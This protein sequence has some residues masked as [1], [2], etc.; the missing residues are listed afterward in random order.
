VT[1]IREP[2]GTSRHRP[3]DRREQILVAARDLFVSESYPNVTMA[4]I[5]QQVNITAGALYRHFSNKQVLLEEVFAENFAWV[6]DQIAAEQYA[7]AVEAALASVSDRPYLSELWTREIRYLTD[8]ARHHLR[9]RTQSWISSLSP[10]IRSERPDFDRDQQELLGWAI[11]SLISSVGRA[12]MHT[13]VALRSEAVRQGL[14][15]ITTVRLTPGG[16]ER[17]STRTGPAPFSMRERLLIAATEQFAARGYQETSLTSLGAAAEVTGS[18]L[19]GYFSSKAE[20]LR[21]VIERGT[22]ELWIGLDRALANSR[23][24]SEALPAI[25]KGHVEAFVSWAHLYSGP[26]GEPEIDRIAKAAQREYVA[27]WVALLQAIEPDVEQRVA[28]ARVLL[29]LFL[30]ADLHL[31]PR[32]ACREAFA[33]NVSAL[34]LAVLLPDAPNR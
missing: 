17:P 27:E 23:T 2:Q 30:I 5:S 26:T 1:T 32:L 31:N 20:V 8:D 25:V 16:A 28:R 3:R 4:K 19:Y 22:H 14:Q 6:E 33:D 21:A 34:A 9:R 11:F 24:A 18:N 29:A 12:A 7:L 15:S 10:A 13:P